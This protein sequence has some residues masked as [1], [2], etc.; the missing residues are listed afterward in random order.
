MREKERERE[1]NVRQCKRVIFH[2]TEYAIRYCEHN[3]TSHHI[4]SHHITEAEAE[5][6]AEAEVEVEVET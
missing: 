3:I 4:T 1:R 6:E 5:A 2:L